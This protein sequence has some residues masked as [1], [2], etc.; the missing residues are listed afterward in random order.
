[1]KNKKK[2]K[3]VMNWIWILAG[4]L[5]LIMKLEYGLCWAFSAFLYRGEL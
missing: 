5:L 3:K 1:M 4:L 2:T